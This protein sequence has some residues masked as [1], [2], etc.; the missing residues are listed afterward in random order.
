MYRLIAEHF[1][2]RAYHDLNR[3]DVAAIVRRDV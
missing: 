3:H 2:R 1:V